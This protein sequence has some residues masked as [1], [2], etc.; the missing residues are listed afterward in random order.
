MLAT[1]TLQLRHTARPAKP[2]VKARFLA[3]TDGT[4]LE[5]L[6][7]HL[8]AV[9]PRLAATIEQMFRRLASEID[10]SSR[11]PGSADVPP[12]W[13]RQLDE[14]LVRWVRDRYVPVQVASLKAGWVYLE[15]AASRKDEDWT[16]AG[17]TRDLE[18]WLDVRAGELVRQITERQREA[19]QAELRHWLIDDP[20]PTEWIARRLERHIG[21]LR[22]QEMTLWRMELAMEADGVP[23]PQ[24]E[25]ALR[26]RAR[27]MLRR[28][29]ETIART[30]VSTAWHHGEYWSVRRLVAGGVIHNPAKRWTTAEDDRACAMCESLDNETVGLDDDFSAGISLPPAHPNCRCSLAYGE[31]SP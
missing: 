15:R 16:W 21:L 12:A 31:M 1:A 3:V 26:Q 14:A 9:A 13:L 22:Q 4:A 5:K 28:R 25:R 19:I 10:W 29:A 24:I 18:Q 11:P 23:G 2:C 7:R 6:G 20:K 8:D 27:E 30:E 17:G